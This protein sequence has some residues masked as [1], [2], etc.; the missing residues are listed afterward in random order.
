MLNLNGKPLI[1]WTIEETLMSKYIDN[2]VISTDDENV[3]NFSKNYKRINTP[4]IRPK[5]LSSDKAS[6]LD[7][8]LH[9]LSFFK[10]SGWLLFRFII[11]FIYVDV[12]FFATCIQSYFCGE[13]MH[14]NFCYCPFNHSFLFIY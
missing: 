14:P 9:T 1:A 11:R 5:E 13:S 3:I 6:S 4:F 8:L 7:V 2:I 12:S 10:S